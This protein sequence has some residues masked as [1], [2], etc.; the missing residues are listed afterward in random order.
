MAALPLLL[1]CLAASLLSPSKT[2]ADALDV[3]VQAQ[4]LK[5]HVPGL[6]LEVV[7]NGKVGLKPKVSG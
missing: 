1:L 7:Q 3:Y 6:A 2:R 4:L 5:Q